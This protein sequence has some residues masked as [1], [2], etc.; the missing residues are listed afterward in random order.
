MR[1]LARQLLRPGLTVLVMLAPLLA[2]GFWQL[3]RLAWKHNLL[4]AITNAEA[5]PA[6]NLP[7]DPP[8]F[9]KV[10]VAGVLRPLQDQA[11]AR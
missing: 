10:S 6:V 3:E 5:A 7:S 4:T 8:A 2:L 9:T 1:P 11:R